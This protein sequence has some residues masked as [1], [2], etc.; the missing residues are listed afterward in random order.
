MT[1]NYVLFFIINHKLS[2]EF[3]FFLSCM[4]TLL[5]CSNMYIC[6][7]TVTFLFSNSSNK[8]NE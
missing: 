7:I 1:S 3:V 2:L 4:A 6:C 5:Y 8:I